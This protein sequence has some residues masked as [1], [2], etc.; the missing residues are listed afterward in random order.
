MDEMALQSDYDLKW[1][2]GNFRN[3]G[4]KYVGLH[5]ENLES[6]INDNKDVGI[7]MAWE[8]LQD[9]EL[10]EIYSSYFEEDYKIS[11]YDIIVNTKS[12]EI[13]DFIYNGLNSRYDKKLFKVLSNENDTYAILLKG[14]INDMVYVKD[15]SFMDVHYKG[16][17]LKQVPYTSKLIKLGLGFDNKKIELI[18]KSGL[19]VLGLQIIIYGQQTN[20]LEHYLMILK[21]LI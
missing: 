1:W 5:E 7:I 2:F 19:E 11:K 18:R 6:M 21:L 4:I 13:F 9:R 12:K 3:L 14:T 20:I 15:H 8:L 17:P 16:V 10:K